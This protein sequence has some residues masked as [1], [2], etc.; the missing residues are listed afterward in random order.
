MIISVVTRSMNYILYQRMQEFIPKSVHTFR[1]TGYNQHEDCFHYVYD[2][3]NMFRDVIVN[4]DE[5]CY[6]YD[7]DKVLGLIDYMDKNDYVAAG[8]PDGGVVETRQRNWAAMNPF[9]NIFFTDRIKQIPGFKDKNVI[10]NF[11]YD[12]SMLKYKPEFVDISKSH[13]DWNSP[14]GGFF[15]WMLK[16]DKKLLYLC[17]ETHSDGVST[18]LK[19]HQGN[20]FCIHGW[21]SRN[22]E[23]DY[24]T[25]ERLDNI[26]KFA[27]DKKNAN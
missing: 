15:Y 27:K 12:D 6:I 25:T 2:L 7:F 21:Y 10:K 26:Y 16:Y 22:Y 20:D 1:F 3:I 11:P 4:V 17:A 14:F 9:F 8:M 5:D 24:Y 23:K 19:D 18:I 13:T